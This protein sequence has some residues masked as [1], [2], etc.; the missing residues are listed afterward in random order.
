MRAAESVLE[1]PDL[2]GTRCRSDDV[3]Y[4]AALHRSPIAGRRNFSVRD[5]DSSDRRAS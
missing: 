5:V 2:S 1:P 3:G 4:A